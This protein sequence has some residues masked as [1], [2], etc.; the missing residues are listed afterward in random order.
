MVIWN[1]IST[2]IIVIWNVISTPI[3][4]ATPTNTCQVFISIGNYIDMR[5]YMQVFTGYI[6]RMLFVTARLGQL[7]SRYKVYNELV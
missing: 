6:M 2:P 5:V 7:G 4:V 3:I 1:V